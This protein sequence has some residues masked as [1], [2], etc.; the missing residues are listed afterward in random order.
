MCAQVQQM[1]SYID[2]LQNINVVFDKNLDVD[3]VLGSI[4]S[5]YDNFNMSYHLNNMD[6]ALMEFYNLFLTIEAGVKK[7]HGAPQI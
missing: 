3:L 7:N 1:K 6:K 2:L 4:P 5:S